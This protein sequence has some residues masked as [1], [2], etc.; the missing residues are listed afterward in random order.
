M[1][2]FL[3]SNVSDS[4]CHQTE[5]QVERLINLSLNLRRKQSITL[6]THTAQNTSL[7]SNI[8]L[9]RIATFTRTLAVWSLP[10]LETV[11]PRNTPRSEKYCHEKNV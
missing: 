1:F 9:I 2:L 5:F 6:T 11:S 10:A 8:P 3:T 7:T 4:E